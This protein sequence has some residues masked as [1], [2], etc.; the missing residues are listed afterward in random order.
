MKGLDSH[1]VDGDRATVQWAVHKKHELA[2][3]LVNSL[4][5][6]IEHGKL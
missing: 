1:P 4:P 3:L 2:I 5:G 6:H